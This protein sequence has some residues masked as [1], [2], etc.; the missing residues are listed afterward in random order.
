MTEPDDP[1]PLVG[2]APRL[3]E[4]VRVYAVG[5]V[6]G[7]L[8]LLR[9]MDTL[10]DADARSAPGR[11][12]QIMLGDYID[13]GPDS[14][15]VVEH[16]LARRRTTELVTLRGNHEGYMLRLAREPS[17]LAHWCRFGGRE[18][19]ASYGIDLSHLDEHE[20]A[21]QAVAIAQRV[22]ATVP[23]SHAAFYAAT[24]LYR[25][26]GDYLFVH[27]GIR[28]GVP[29]SRQAE[30]DLVMIR[31]GFLDSEAD[32]GR[33]VVHGHTPQDAPEIRPNRIG[34]DTRAYAS[35][36]LTCLVLEGA[37]RRFL[38]T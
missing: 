26:L 28:P 14:A 35:G 13:R 25:V 12:I 3:P 19:L 34:I 4:G 20:L 36:V 37:E 30:G 5:D 9:A 21:A 22:A 29:L 17:V 27:A 23:Q 16:L 6:H 15:G 7:R 24:E 38:T 8:D 10:I 1:P 32:F 18:A 31:Q 2:R 33:V 11:V